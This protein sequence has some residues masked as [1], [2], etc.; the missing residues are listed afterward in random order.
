MK[1][2]L[3]QITDWNSGSV[4]IWGVYSSQESAEVRAKELMADEN[5]DLG[6][7]VFAMS[8]QD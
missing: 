1:V 3:L 2:W 7:K 4:D 8:V 6:W 5:L